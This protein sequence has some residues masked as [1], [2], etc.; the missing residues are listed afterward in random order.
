MARMTRRTFL[1]AGAAAAATLAFPS[2]GFGEWKNA[3]KT[4]IVCFGGGVRYSETFGDPLLANLPGIRKNLLPQGTLYNNFF[5]DGSTSHV[6]G[7]VQL[8][9]GRKSTGEEKIPKSPTIFEYYRQAKGN[10]R[11]PDSKACIV[12]HTTLDV[13][14]A[15]SEHSDFGTAFSGLVFSPRLLMYDHLL[16]VMT[17]EEDTTSDIYRQ[18]KELRERIWVEED[19]EHIEDPD[20]TPPQYAGDA[21]NFVRAVLDKAKVPQLKSE[22]LGDELVWYFAETAM[23]T[24]RPDVLV[25]SFAGP[26]IAHRGSFS[27]YVTRIQC[28]DDLVLRVYGEIRKNKYYQ[29][30][31]LFIVAPDC[32]RSLGGH[33]QGGFTSHWNGDDGCRHLWA[34]A[35]GPGVKEKKIISSVCSQYDI[36]PTIAEAMGFAAQHAEGKPL[37]S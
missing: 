12:A 27:D 35:I 22:A 9:T 18:A 8:L 2:I 32:G 29:T 36:A 33:G 3:T 19:F 10:K 31:T 20:R 25:I 24:I 14:F 37:P 23:S 26:D 6:G 1:K 11:I 16:Q 28:L 4:V 30:G 34:L 5:N 13:G 7:M 17:A 15:V 21:Q